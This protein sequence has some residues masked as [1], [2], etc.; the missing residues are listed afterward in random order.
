MLRLLHIRAAP[1]HHARAAASTASRVEF[2]PTHATPAH[3][4]SNLTFSSG[5]VFVKKAAP[6]VEACVEEKKG[7]ETMVFVF[8]CLS[9]THAAATYS[10][11]RC[12]YAV[13]E[14]SIMLFTW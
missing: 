3:Q 8:C 10:L 9:H 14:L 7:D 5:I 6:T 12:V 1:H 2:W 4:I 11:P 13:Y